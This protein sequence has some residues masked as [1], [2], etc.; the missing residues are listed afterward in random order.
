MKISLAG[1]ALKDSKFFIARRCG[2]GEMDGKWEFP[3]GKA[4]DG[5]TL[6]DAL[7]REFLEE[8]GIK[9]RCGARL[10]E[11]GFTHRGETHILYAYRIYFTESLESIV[12]T[13]HSDWKWASPDEI[14]ALDFTPSDLSLLPFIEGDLS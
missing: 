14:R 7:E 9:T 10:G 1:V 8:F 13:E 3:G 2:G 11:S 12:L 5:E 6:E 4:E